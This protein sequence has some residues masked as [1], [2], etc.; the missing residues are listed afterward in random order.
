MVVWEVTQYLKNQV[1]TVI[2][3]YRRAPSKRRTVHRQML[4]IARWHGV[5]KHVLACARIALIRVLHVAELAVDAVS[6]V[7]FRMRAALHD[8]PF[9]HD[10]DEIRVADR[11]EAVRNGE[12]RAILH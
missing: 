6:G 4:G 1:F 7:K 8:L 12:R 2:P 5:E 9:L 10:E 11:R 3:Q